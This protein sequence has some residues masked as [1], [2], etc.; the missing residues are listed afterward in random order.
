MKSGIASKLLRLY[1]REPENFLD[2][3]ELWRKFTEITQESS[4]RRSTRI[5]DNYGDESVAPDD[6]QDEMFEDEIEPF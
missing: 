2:E 6:M 1:A 4:E 3:R 5:S